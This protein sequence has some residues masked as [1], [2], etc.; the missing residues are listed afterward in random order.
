MA[1]K[2]R[3]TFYDV[4]GVPR[5]AKVTDIGRAYN[6][7]KA[8]MQKETWAPDSR[9]EARIHEAYA[10]LSDPARRDAYD[11][12]LV[13]HRK[14]LAKGQ[15]AAFGGLAAVVVAGAAFYA[16][17][18]APPPAAAAGR[19]PHEILAEA[20]RSVGRV[21]T[22]DISGSA[23]QAGIAFTIEPGVMATPC[24]GLP[25]GATFVV[26]I[27]SRPV[28]ARLA[29]SEDDIGICRLAMEGQG[30]WPLPISNV[31]PRPGDRVLATAANA[32]GEVTLVEGTVKRLVIEPKATVKFIEVSMPLA[33]DA[34]GGPLFDTQGRIVGIAA[35][36]PSDGKLRHMAIP[37]SWIREARVPREAPPPG[38]AA[39]APR[40]AAGAAGSDVPL[41]IP[42]SGDPSKTTDE[43]REE[44][45]K[46]FRPDPRPDTP[47]VENAK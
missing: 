29:T 39:P 28:P 41:R 31:E 26:S 30:S 22:I 24:E 8:E 20:S 25:A 35:V 43:R 11:A 33:P 44:L 2:Q 5:T 19:A 10:V 12:S 46:A 36:A 34:A 37:A 47:E 1:Q 3:E 32:A 38:G 7:L 17:R 13:V 27:A 16:L 40:E 9:K 4:L 45:R 6:R 42:G 18:P 23:V 21:K 14:P 15:I